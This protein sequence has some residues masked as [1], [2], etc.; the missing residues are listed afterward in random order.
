MQNSYLNIE[1]WD[2][3]A[4]YPS[5]PGII[6][7]ADLKKRSLYINYHANCRKDIAHA[8]AINEI[9]KNADT[10]YEF[11]ISF[12]KSESLSRADYAG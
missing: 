2:F 1:A 11:N 5:L 8:D 9:L 12:E 4:I 10:P 3:D 7:K 6:N